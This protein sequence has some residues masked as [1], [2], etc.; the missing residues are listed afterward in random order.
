MR[1][2]LRNEWWQNEDPTVLASRTNVL[3]WYPKAGKLQ[4][5]RP[6]FLDGNGETRPGKT[7]TVDIAALPPEAAA[8]FTAVAER[9]RR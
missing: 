5:A 3:R 7:V 1:K 9:V 6:D 2:E 8:V 4:C